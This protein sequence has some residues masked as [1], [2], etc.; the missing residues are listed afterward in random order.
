MKLFKIFVM[1]CLGILMV[2]TI[3][4]S[5]ECSKLEKML[6]KCKSGVINETTPPKDSGPA[7]FP[8]IKPPA[9]PIPDDVDPPDPMPVPDP[10]PIPVERIYYVPAIFMDKN[11]V[12]HNTWIGFTRDK[13]LCTEE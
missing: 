8:S 12:P 1:S 4:Y 11:G 9:P 7:P 6:G 13:K 10:V 2:S 3:C 5:R